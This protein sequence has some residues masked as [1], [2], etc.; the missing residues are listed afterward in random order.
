MIKKD[1]TLYTQIDGRKKIKEIVAVNTPVRE[2]EAPSSSCI[3]TH[4]KE[5][6]KQCRNTHTHY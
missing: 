2:R 3:H 4:P 5:E 1:I 6:S